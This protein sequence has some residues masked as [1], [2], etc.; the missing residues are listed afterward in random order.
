MLP[1]QLTIKNFNHWRHFL[2]INKRICICNCNTLCLL[3]AHLADADAD[4][5]ADAAHVLNVFCH[6]ALFMHSA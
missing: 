3:A 2:I 6:L 4:V 1:G 5:D